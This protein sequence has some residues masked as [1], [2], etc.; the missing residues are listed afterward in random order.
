MISGADVRALLNRH[1]DQAVSIYLP[2][3]TLPDEADKNDI[4]LKNLVRDA[5]RALSD[6]GAE[7]ADMRQRIDGWIEQ[8]DIAHRPETRGLA[9]FFIDGDLQGHPLPFA[10]REEVWIDTRPL[11]TPLIPLLDEERSYY[12]ITLDQNGP[13]LYRGDAEGLQPLEREAADQSLDKIRALTQLPANVGFHASGSSSGGQPAARYHAQ[14]EA[15]ED[16]EQ[17]QLNEFARGIAHAVDSLMKKKRGPLVAVGDPNLLGMFRR[18]CRH[19][20]LLDEAVA[21]SPSGL[22]AEALHRE[23]YEVARGALEAEQ[24]RAL[25][26]LRAAIGRGD[27]T[28]LTRRTQIRE[29]AEQGRV[30][31]LF[32]LH[33]RAVPGEEDVPDGPHD[34]DALVQA[35]LVQ[36]GSLRVVQPGDLPNKATAAALLRG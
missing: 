1:A 16:Y 3:T 12:V 20:G 7:L 2:F 4:R 14:G 24:Q 23:T 13:R 36:G 35:T 18:H 8:A 17:I 19:S 11:V 9:L 10:P 27:D 6:E 5:E 32:V 34:I 22:D 21:K 29:T 28:A 33:P 15:P 25:E 31:T 26:D 30:D